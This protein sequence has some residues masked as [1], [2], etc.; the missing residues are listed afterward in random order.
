MALRGGDV[1]HERGLFAGIDAA[2]VAVVA[3]VRAPPSV[4]WGD[5]IV[6]TEP[7]PEGIAPPREHAAYGRE[8][9]LLRVHAEARPHL[10]H[11]PLE[12]GLRETW[13]P[14]P[15]FPL[16]ECKGRRPKARHPVHRRPAA[17]G[18]PV[19]DAKSEVPSR[20]KAAAGRP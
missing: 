19:E 8:G 14:E 2:E 15:F 7:I 18:P 17:G 3:P 1:R 13:N 9:G 12:G 20:H 5:V 4:L 11:E 6:D 16:L 10:V